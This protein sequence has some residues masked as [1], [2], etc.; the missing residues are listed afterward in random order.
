AT[1]LGAQD[2]RKFSFGDTTPLTDKDLLNEDYARKVTTEL[3]TDLGLSTSRG[4]IKFTLT[5]PNVPFL[6]FG[7]KEYPTLY[8]KRIID[9]TVK[10]N[11]DAILPREP[12]T[13]LVKSITLNYSVSQEISLN[14]QKNNTAEEFFHVGPFGHALQ[15]SPDYQCESGNTAPYAFP[16]FANRGNLYLGLTEAQPGETYS[17]L[18]QMVEGTGSTKVD[19]DSG[20]GWYY[21]AA[22]N[23]WKS[24][25]DYVQADST[26]QFLNSGIVQISMP[27]DLASENTLMRDTRSWLRVSVPN[28]PEAENL[29]VAVHSNA[30]KATFKDQGNDLS[31]LTE[32]LPAESLAKLVNKDAQI[33]KVNQPY[34]SFGGKIKEEN[35]SYYTRT[36]ER[37]RHKHRAINIWDFERLVLQHFPSVYKVKCL[38]H[39]SPD[40][41][42]APGHVTLVIVSNLRNQNGV[43]LLKPTTSSSKLAAIKDLCL[44]L[45]NPFLN[46][47]GGK[48]K[49]HVSDP[50]YEQIKVEFKVK[51]HEIPGLDANAERENLNEAIKRY[52]S[53]WAYTEGVDILFEGRVHKSQILHFVENYRGL[54]GTEELVDFVTCFK[55]YHSVEDEDGVLEEQEADVITPTRSSA[56]LVSHKK[57]IINLVTDTENCTCEDDPVQTTPT[58]ELE[59]IDYWTVGSD[60]IVTPGTS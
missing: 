54:A 26:D 6:A 39:T 60:F 44:S 4:F 59:G 42:R 33:K 58:E 13:P 27:D 12:Y 43:D 9:Q 25:D 57:H 16:H 32:P 24:L 21:L 30:V 37:L 2:I 23:T 34:A 19:K 46:R 40:S 35:E 38:N 15:Y 3:P 8:T 20:F 45:S 10:N 55:M 48:E 47:P 36:S 49:L 29:M 31:R 41:E 1:P 28:T 17:F 52:L 50:S 7:H 5:E 22:H 53:P 51:F 18:F 11:A 56:I 14:D